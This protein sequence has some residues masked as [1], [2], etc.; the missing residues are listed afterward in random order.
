METTARWS[1]GYGS[2]GIVTSGVPGGPAI[3][4]SRT[5]MPAEAWTRSIRSITSFAFRRGNG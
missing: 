1:E 5:W 2:T 4:L 3:P